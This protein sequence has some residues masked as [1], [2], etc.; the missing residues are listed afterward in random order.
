MRGPL[1]FCLLH[2]RTCD[3]IN[4]KGDLRMK[5]IPMFT[6]EYGV[7]S[8]I[9]AE[10]PYGETA[11]IYIRSCLPG[12]LENLLSE[13]VGFC[14]ACGAE[15]IYA[16]GEAELEKYPLHS[17]IYEMRGSISEGQQAN[18][19]PVT[20]ETMEIWRSIANERMAGVDN[21]GTITL[22]YAKKLLH[23][24]GAYFVHENKALLGIGLV[25]EDI[26]RL[27]AATKPGAGEIVLRTLL[28][29]VP[30]MPVRLEVASTNSSAIRLYERV[31]FVKTGEKS[32]W[33]QVR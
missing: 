25:Q 19:W 9:L 33:Y 4:G 1:Y 20:E 22:S 8:L 26:L 23:E 3:K 29:I 5:D 27:I 10:I 28:S 21:H 30:Q 15:K 11:Y 7:A 24:G 31:G 13:C 14:R 12:E 32:R 16:T 17:V 18:L 6:T 2:G